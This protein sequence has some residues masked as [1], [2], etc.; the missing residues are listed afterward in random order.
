MP[1]LAAEEGLG[2][3]VTARAVVVH[4]RVRRVRI[5]SGPEMFDDAVR[6]AMLQYRCADRGDQPITVVQTFRFSVQ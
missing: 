1:E 6:T 3:T 2:G 5:V 4:G